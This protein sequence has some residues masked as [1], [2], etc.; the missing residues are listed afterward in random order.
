MVATLG[1]ATL[2]LLLLALMGELVDHIIEERHLGVELR[3][4]SEVRKRAECVDGS[5]YAVS[6]YDYAV[7]GV[8]Q[9]RR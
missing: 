7:D 3:E 8:V 1:I 6:E 2:L 5:V 9:Q 4:S